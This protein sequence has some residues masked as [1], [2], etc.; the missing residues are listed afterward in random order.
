MMNEH[1]G[2]PKWPSCSCCQMPMKKLLKV[3]DASANLF[4]H[5]TTTPEYLRREKD[6]AQWGEWFA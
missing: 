1:V 6:V 5:Q 3:M 2:K 4:L